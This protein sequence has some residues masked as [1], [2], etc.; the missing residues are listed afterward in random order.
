MAGIP[1]SPPGCLHLLLSADHDAIE[2]CLRAADQD[3]TVLILA[4]GVMALLH[5][6]LTRFPDGC[7]VLFSAPDLEARGLAAVAA[8]RDIGVV[9]DVGITTLLADHRHCLSWK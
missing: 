6:P 4:D 1:K 2:D 9:E 8:E 3:D 7:G 5:T